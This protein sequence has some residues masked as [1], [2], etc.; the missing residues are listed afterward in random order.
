[1]TETIGER[2]RR[3]N[4]IRQSEIYQAIKAQWRETQSNKGIASPQALALRDKL[5]ALES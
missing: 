3:I 2:A 5:V 1:M 4:Q